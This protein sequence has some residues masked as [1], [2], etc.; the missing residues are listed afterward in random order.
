MLCNGWMDG[1]MDRKDI[2]CKPKKSI[3]KKILK[4]QTLN[5]KYHIKFSYRNPAKYQKKRLYRHAIGNAQYSIGF[6]QRAIARLDKGRRQTL[7]IA[8]FIDQFIIIQ[9]YAI[10]QLSAPPG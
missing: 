3:F 7:F 10:M 8:S 9:N 2:F 6:C 4:A 5:I 1:W